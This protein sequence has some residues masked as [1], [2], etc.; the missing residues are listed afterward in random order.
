MEK[1]LEI[2]ENNKDIHMYRVVFD[3]LS[4]M[5]TKKNYSLNKSGV[6]FN[7]NSFNDLELGELEKMISQFLLTKKRN[8]EIEKDRTDTL[9]KLNATLSKNETSLDN[10]KIQKIP[11]KPKRQEQGYNVDNYDVDT[12]T[13]LN[14]RPKK[15]VYSRIYSSMYSRASPVKPKHSEEISIKESGC[16]EDDAISETE[17]LFG[18][19]DLEDEGC[20]EDEACLEEID[21]EILDLF[22]DDQEI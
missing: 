8:E 16:G 13:R 15:G 17:S 20:L 22:G 21:P 6:F 14:Y 19:R 18:E 3:T 1:I 9:E 11:I 2:I 10:V 5:N 4:Q 7:L 12:S